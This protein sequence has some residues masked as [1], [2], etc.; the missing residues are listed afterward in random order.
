MDKKKKKKKRKNQSESYIL[1][2]F[3]DF[4]FCRKNFAPLFSTITKLSEFFVWPKSNF[5]RKDLY[6][7]AIVHVVR[8]TFHI[9]IY[10]C[11]S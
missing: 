9:S 2:L 8:M 4:R 3:I 5:T 1:K 6:M 7:H 10:A 11:Y